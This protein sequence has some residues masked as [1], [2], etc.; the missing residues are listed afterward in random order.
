[1]DRRLQLSDEAKEGLD[2]LL[3]ELKELDKLPPRPRKD[4]TL[5][6]TG[7]PLEGAERVEGAGRAFV[8][9]R[10]GRHGIE[11]VPWQ[12]RRMARGGRHDIERRKGDRA[13]SRKACRQALLG[14]S[15][16]RRVPRYHQ[17]LQRTRQ[18]RAT[19]VPKYM[20]TSRQSRWV[21][22]FRPAARHEH[23]VDGN[24]VEALTRPPETYL[25]V[26]SKCPNRS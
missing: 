17:A 20:C 21:V 15:S 23:D 24:E 9:P 4:R 10:G 26:L 18:K 22:R 11:P 6:R 8:W 5:S 2:R 3:S 14:N 12:C 1:M 7:E 19:T 25:S 13:E 16:N